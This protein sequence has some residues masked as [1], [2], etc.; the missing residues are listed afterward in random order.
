MD[1]G[2]TQI[3]RISPDGVARPGGHYSHACSVGELV[4]ISGQL[5]IR[6]DGSHTAQRPFAEQAEQAIDNLLGVLQGCGLG[7]EALAKVTVYV[8][9][10]AH[11]PEFDAIYAR[12][13][14]A[15]RPARAVVPVSELH[16]GYLVE[17]EATAVRCDRL[18]T[19]P[20]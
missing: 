12:K 6:A 19:P 2:R 10:V 15:V 1:A 16:Y 9:G 17:I 7:P 14:G 5:G 4:F 18:A 11:W 20:A 3:D 13:L 8:A